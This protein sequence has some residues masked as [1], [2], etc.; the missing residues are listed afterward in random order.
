MGDYMDSV[1]KMWNLQAPARIS[2]EQ[3]QLQLSPM[4]MSFL[5]E[6]RRIRSVRL[7]QELGLRLLYPTVMDG[8]KTDRQT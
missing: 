1:A 5:N 6:S 8:L 7:A 4:V 3:A 2:R